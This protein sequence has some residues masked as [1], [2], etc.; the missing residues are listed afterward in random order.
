MEYQL[1]LSHTCEFDLM[2]S[3]DEKFYNKIR[4]NPYAE[5]STMP[6][7]WGMELCCIES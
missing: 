7:R 2:P 3:M 6:W 4:L 5:L 1:E